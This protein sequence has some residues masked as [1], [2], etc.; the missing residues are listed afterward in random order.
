M[1]LTIQSQ[2]Y[3][4]RMKKSHSWISIPGYTD[5]KLGWLHSTYKHSCTTEVQSKSSPLLQAMWKWP[6]TTDIKW[7]PSSKPITKEG[8]TAVKPPRKLSAP[9]PSHGNFKLPLALHIFTHLASP[10]APC[11]GTGFKNWTSP[12]CSSTFFL[13]RFSV[14]L[15]AISWPRLKVM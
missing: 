6:K 5:L 3:C 4:H 9:P 12:E 2:N 8:G 10:S 13:T 14:S 1:N 15:T 11:L 7:P